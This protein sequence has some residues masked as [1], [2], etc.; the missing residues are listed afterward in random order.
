M[1]RASSGFDALHFEI[2][3]SGRPVDPLQFLPPR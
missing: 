1:G 2:R 3:R